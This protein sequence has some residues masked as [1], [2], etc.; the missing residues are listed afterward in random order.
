[1]SFPP[2][3]APEPT[4]QFTVSDRRTSTLSPH[5]DCCRVS[6]GAG[7]QAAALAAL[8]TLAANC[9]IAADVVNQN[10]LGRYSDSGSCDYDCGFKEQDWNW[11]ADYRGTN[12]NLVQAVG[13]MNITG[14]YTAAF[15][16]TQTWVNAA[17]PGFSGSLNGS[18]ATINRIDAA[19]IAAGGVETPEQ[20]A[21]L[22]AAFANLSSVVQGSLGQAN[23]ALQNLAAFL[24]WEQGHT[25]V[26]QN[27]VT[28]SQGYIKTD[29]TNT[30][31]NLI[32]QIAC[33]A[34]DVQNSFNNMF[35]DIN[36]KF[37]TMQTCFTT[38]TSNL[39]AAIK[40]GDSVAGVFLILQSDSSVV[41]EQIVQAQS[42]PPSSPLRQLHLNISGNEW[43]NLVQKANAELRPAS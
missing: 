36:N 5:Q 10:P 15:Q 42:Y 25:G 26:L 13:S 40:A 27:L 33:G 43:G 30:E 7:A 38:V 9:G 41:S 29:A 20:D 11:W 1:M 14:P 18:L 24:S 34:G 28:S 12:T 4:S 2:C 17:L 6:S 8:A 39:L 21:E 22:S 3:A 32:G 31:N 23:Q 35:N 16:P 19:I 37:A